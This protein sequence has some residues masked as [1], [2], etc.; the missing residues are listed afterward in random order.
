L[1]GPRL[2]LVRHGETIWS[3]SGQHTSRTDLPL[4]ALGEQE[5]VALKPLLERQHF[6]I[7]ASS[8]MQRAVRTAELAG[9]Q[10]TVDEDLEEWD[11][12]DLEGLTTD[13][14]RGRYPGWTIWDGPWPGG[15]EPAQV[16]ARA[17]RALEAV[18]ALAPGAEAL[19]FA[20]GHILRAL[21]ARWLG[22]PATDG[23]LF[24]LGTATVSVLGWEH[25]T[26]AVDHWNVPPD[27]GSGA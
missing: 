17:D 15:E 21:A 10:P 26:P 27:F 9:F 25:G 12:G 24:I 6:D 22:R 20:H 13:Q 2:W 11:Y 1:S 23:C 3:A 18:Q 8:P 16:A 19:F 5:A 4:T 7:V 14:I